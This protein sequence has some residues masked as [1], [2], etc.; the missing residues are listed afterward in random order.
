MIGSQEHWGFHMIRITVSRSPCHKL[1]WGSRV[2][3]TRW[4]KSGWGEGSCERRLGSVPR[5]VGA[6]EN[7]KQSSEVQVAFQ[8]DAWPRVWALCCRV[9][10]PYSQAP[11][12]GC[13]QPAEG[14]EGLGGGG[15]PQGDAAKPGP[16]PSS[17]LL[18]AP[19]GAGPCLQ[20]RCRL[21]PLAR[22]R[23]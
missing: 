23:G 5:A 15:G 13:Q 21:P 7:R 11:R 16:R 3:E 10:V 9:R 6:F 14:A 8:S 20:P 4:F 18:P 17:L 19:S 2:C 22:H 1:H 12:R